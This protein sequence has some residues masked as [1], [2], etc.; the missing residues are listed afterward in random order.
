MVKGVIYKL[1]LLSVIFFIAHF[2]LNLFLVS[3]IELNFIISLHSFF[4]LFLL[5]LHFIMQKA[6]KK[7]YD[8]LWVYYI[9][10][11][12]LKFFSFLG[13]LFL[14]K[15]VFEVNKSQ[16]LVHAF[17]WFFLYLIVEVFYMITLLKINKVEIS[18]K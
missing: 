6:A 16:V 8:R 3:P 7:K 2:L 17:L 14:L 11:V 15:Q 13:V 10:S 5:G 4:V 18:N 9:G 1:V 12:S